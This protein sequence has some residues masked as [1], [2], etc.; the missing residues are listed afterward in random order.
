MNA[1]GQLARALAAGM[2]GWASSGETSMLARKDEIVSMRI[3]Y[4][5]SNHIEIEVSY[6]YSGT[7]GNVAWLAP[8]LR[9]RDGQR[10]PAH[11][12]TVPG[13]VTRGRS[14][15]WSRLY[16]QAP[17][18]GERPAGDAQLFIKMYTGDS[19]HTTL[20]HR[21]FSWTS[22]YRA[23]NRQ[24]PRLL[25]AVTSQGVDET[26]TGRRPRHW[27]TPGGG[28]WASAQ[29]FFGAAGQQAAACRFLM[30]EDLEGRHQIGL[31]A[32]RNGVAAGERRW[33]FVRD[34]VARNYT[35]YDATASTHACDRRSKGRWEEVILL[36]GREVGRLRYLV[37]ISIDD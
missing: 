5:A 10:H 28:S 35:N 31:V 4:E 24:E 33:P 3:L 6:E 20:A 7:H 37:D 17:P 32:H 26:R 16:F 11:T 1:S 19:A 29:T 8:E 14:T 36:D 18:F 30:F 9:S 34:S 22:G 23:V 2:V 27:Q 13:P 12:G 25:I 21:T 15:T